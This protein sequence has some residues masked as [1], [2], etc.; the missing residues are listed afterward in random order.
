MGMTQA[1]AQQQGPPAR[2]KQQIESQTIL[3]YET[4]PQGTL[5]LQQIHSWSIHQDRAVP[6][7]WA[8]SRLEHSI[9]GRL[10]LIHPALGE[11]LETAGCFE[12]RVSSRQYTLTT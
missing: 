8:A 12:L 10:L 4:W 1:P 6:M 9:Q 11:C 5:L 7:Y 2:D 3:F